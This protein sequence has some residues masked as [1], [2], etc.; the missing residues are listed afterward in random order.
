MTTSGNTKSV[1]LSQATQSYI[2]F[3]FSC[4]KV[5]YSQKLA[6]GF[7]N[8]KLRHKKSRSKWTALSITNEME[9]ES[10]ID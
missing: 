9:R 4:D 10:K 1:Q 3:F 8:Q 5:T 6:I 2:V 7:K